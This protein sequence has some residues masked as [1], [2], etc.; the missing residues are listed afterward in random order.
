MNHKTMK[1]VIIGVILLFVLSTF[2]TST[3]S[4][5]S[6]FK[7]NTTDE[8]MIPDY[9]ED[10]PLFERNF[11]DLNFITNEFIVKFKEDIGLESSSEDTRIRIFS[12]YFLDKIPGVNAIK[13]VFKNRGKPFLDSLGL[14]NVYKVIVSENC[15]VTSIIEDLENDP[16]VE[17]V[18]PEYIMKTSLL[19]NDPYY[20][21]SGSW[22]QSFLDLY[23]LHLI[24][25]EQAWDYSTGSHDVVVAVVDTGVDYNH[26]E[27]ADNY[28]G[29]Y[30]FFNEDD[31]PIDDNGHGTHCAG[32]IGAVGNN[33]EGIVGVNWKVKIMALKAFGSC[34]I[35]LSSDIA[36]AIVWAADNSANVISNSWG[37]E[38]RLPTNK[39]YEDAIRYAYNKGCTV[40][41]AAGNEDDDTRYY[42]PANMKET[43]TVAAINYNEDKAY[44][45]NWGKKVDVCA[46][47][48]DI[49]SLRADNTDLYSSNGANFVPPYDDNAILYKASGTSMSCPFV[50]G[51][52]A[53]LIAN[54]PTLTPD[55]VKTIIRDTTD[56]VDSSEYIGTGKINA[57]E[58]IKRTPVISKINVFPNYGDVHGSIEIIGTAWAEN[59]QSY[60]VE[61]GKGKNPG[62]W[63]IIANSFNTVQNGTIGFLD[64]TTLDEGYYTIKLT[65]ED[66]YGFYYDEEEIVVNNHYNILTVDGS[67]YSKIQDAVDNAGSGDKVI[68]NSG[69]YYENIVIFRSMEIEG[70][71][72]EDTI[73][74][75]NDESGFFIYV[76]DVSISKFTIKTGGTLS[77]KPSGIKMY[78]S[79][80]IISNVILTQASYYSRGFTIFYGHQNSITNC[81]I[82]NKLI[83]IDFIYSNSNN[84]IDC[85]FHNNYKGTILRE[86]SNNTIKNCKIN[87]NEIGIECENLSDRNSFYNNNFIGNQQ[88]SYD[89]GSNSW[90]NGVIGNYWDDYPGEDINED[91]IGDTPY[92]IPGDKN[93]DNYPLMRAIGET[94]NPPNIPGKPSGDETGLQGVPNYYTTI[95]TDPD[96]DKVRYGWDFDGDLIS[97]GWTSYH[98]SGV[99]VSYSYAWF[100]PG[101][102]QVRV[103]A[104]DIYG[105]ESGWSENLTVTI[106]KDEDKPTVKITKPEKALYIMNIRLR[107][108]LIR[109]PF[110]I[111]K[112][113]VKAKANDSTSGINHVE[114]YIDNV[115]TANISNEPFQFTWQKTNGLKL[116]SLNPLHKIKV[117]AYDNAGNSAKDEITVW[118]LF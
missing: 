22:G 96:S 60:K 11:L 81:S 1:L 6:F 52:A 12:G 76:D 40:V 55:M 45:S 35:G 15:D 84:I 13:N 58:A 57:S 99:S 103:K 19:P 90:D 73:L 2:T 10:K 47:G 69:T 113:D 30:D 77:S 101:T 28:I 38:Y 115:L 95:T 62:S 110:I 112:I 89:N 86:S 75:S 3:G 85:D 32:I 74:D 18:Q 26:P 64:T 53:L 91:E 27:L 8:S 116:L 5:S 98:P 33:S 7:R 42:S 9:T 107:K 106:S 92:K 100:E 79:K 21:S 72:K 104:R 88:H 67:T 118:K 49:L 105:E 41:N 66:D 108:Y 50:S 36:E 93:Q 29:G 114:F 82:N 61:Y 4:K 17:Y 25:M 71:S 39:V 97:D 83:G 68:V 14:S 59:F 56:P 46:P 94:S 44:F 48:V 78:S 80:N 111:G 20:V 34:G 24:N 23:G 51:L 87:D 102:F 117:I 109:N 31:D 65:V 54:N 16:N 43:I 70:Y 63:S 37:P